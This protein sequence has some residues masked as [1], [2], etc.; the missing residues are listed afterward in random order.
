LNED[1]KKGILNRTLNEYS[2]DR[3]SI[4]E[5]YLKLADHEYAYMARKSIY[6]AYNAKCND[7]VFT[8]HLLSTNDKRII[9][10]SPNMYLGVGENQNG[11]NILGHTLVQIR[12]KLI[13]DKK[14]SKETSLVKKQ[15]DKVF[16]MYIVLNLLPLWLPLAF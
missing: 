3:L 15:E 8:K 10:N 13:I 9:Y 11:M 2:N 5:L 7:N 12:D 16:K 4:F 14:R 1:E 6:A